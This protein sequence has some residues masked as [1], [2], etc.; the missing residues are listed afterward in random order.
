MHP[1]RESWRAHQNEAAHAGRSSTR[2]GI[3]LADWAP[4]L[5]VLLFHLAFLPGYGIFRDE[6]YYLACA[7]RLD[8]GYVDHPPLVG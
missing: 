1:I 5:A 2:A 3:G 4:A 8:W 6:L 7:R